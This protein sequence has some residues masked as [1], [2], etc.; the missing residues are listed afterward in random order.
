MTKK[1]VLV[2][3]G[4]GYVGSVLVR[5][6]LK[7]GYSVRSFD[8]V[9]HEERFLE[10]FY[11]Y[12]NLDFM[13]GDIKETADLEKSVRDVD[14]VVHLAAI[15]GDP[16][17]AK[18]PELA[19]QTNWDGSKLL[20]DICN[21]TQNIK[22]FIFASTCSNYGKMSGSGYVNEGSTLNPVSLY[23][24]LKVGFE[25]YIL[26]EKTRGDF[27]PVILRF[28][29][30]F[31]VSPRM[32]FDLTVNEFVKDSY[33]GKKLVVFGEKFW[34]PYCH[35]Q[36]LTNACIRM[37]EADQ[38][39]I[40]KDMFNVGDTQENYQKQTIVELIKKHIPELKV[41]FVHKDEDPRDYRV[42]FDKINKTLGFKITKTVNDGVEELITFLESRVVKDPDDAIYRNV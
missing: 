13:K 34:R 32:R 18:Q 17:C 2:T 19:K 9:K 6:L 39:L 30:A 4:V 15:V 22:R 36:D 5:E 10:D 31:G 28:A 35:V 23:A 16:A 29:T 25:K 8:I 1:R 33:M 12:R 42:N 7:N 24:Q 37:L 20:F 21:K 14:Y 27:V 26:A 41:E 40:E 38:E 11:K 3:G